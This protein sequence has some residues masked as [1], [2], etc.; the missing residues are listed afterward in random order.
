MSLYYSRL[1]GLSPGS[2]FFAQAKYIAKSYRMEKRR[3]SM[4]APVSV[5]FAP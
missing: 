3:I 2:L 4:D 5:K 1:S